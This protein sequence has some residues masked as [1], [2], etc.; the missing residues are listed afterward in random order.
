MNQNKT[1][2]MAAYNAV[3]QQYADK[4]ADE[5]LLK[6]TVQQFLADFVKPIAEN[7]LI[8]D[9]GCGPGQVARYLK[10]SLNRNATGI[11][12]SPNMVEIAS[13]IN[14]GITFSV[15]DI[16]LLNDVGLY[17]GIIGLYFIVNFPP[18]V[19]PRVFNQLHRLLKPN[20]KL[21]LSFHTGNNELNR[22]DDLWNSGKG[23]DF[24]FFD[25]EMVSN[26]ME[27]C[28][29]KVT[30]VRL[31]EPDPEIEYPSRRAYAFAE[32]Q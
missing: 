22:V 1:E 28:G 14:P 26:Y 4:Y 9:M 8:C 29:F 24:Y 13:T 17:D 23:C 31:R 15:A 2:V 6:P 18:R 5:I 32:S 11:D 10:N 27:Q 16:L 30:D 7:G 21:L 19:L 12:L 25:P 20:G 3:A